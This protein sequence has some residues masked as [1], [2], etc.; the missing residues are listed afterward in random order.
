MSITVSYF[1]YKR[2]PRTRGGKSLAPSE[3]PAVRSQLHTASPSVEIWPGVEDVGNASWIGEPTTASREI[4][5]AV[6]FVRFFVAVGMVVILNR[7][8]VGN[9]LRLAA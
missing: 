8:R 7:G 3:S 6:E 5:T 4:F 2:V 9:R 1:P